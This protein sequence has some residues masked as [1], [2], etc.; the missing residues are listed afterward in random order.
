MSSE[1]SRDDAKHDH[2]EVDDESDD[3]VKDTESD[4]ESRS[5]RHRRQTRQR[6]V[7]PARLSAELGA[8]LDLTD[9]WS[10]RGDKD[11]GAESD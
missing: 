8:W 7:Q 11:H 5:R 2:A 4:D 3:D 1:I 9:T 6:N 10:D